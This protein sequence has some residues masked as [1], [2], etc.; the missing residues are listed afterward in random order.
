MSRSR[1]RARR[2]RT[3]LRDEFNQKR[4][5]G[6]ALAAFLARVAKSDERVWAVAQ[7]ASAESPLTEEER[8]MVAQAAA[9]H[10]AGMR[11]G[12]R[13]PFEPE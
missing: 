7:A 6:E 5:D 1:T 2:R 12:A 3:Q 13:P 11:S 9:P 8:A 10:L 4:S